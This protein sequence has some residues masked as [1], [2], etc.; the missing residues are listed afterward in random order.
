MTDFVGQPDETIH[1]IVRLQIMAAL[2]ALREPEMLDFIRLRAIIGA[3]DGNLASHLSTLESV[4]YIVIS[5]GF[6][7]KKPRTRI[8]VTVTGRAAL[9]RHTRYLHAILDGS[10]L[11]AKSLRDPKDAGDN[12]SVDHGTASG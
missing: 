6:V 12:R 10:V 9:E 11:D 8:A 5:K 4:G 1:Q 3:S 2:A 7:G